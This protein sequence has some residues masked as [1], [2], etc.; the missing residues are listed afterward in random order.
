MCNSVIAWFPLEARGSGLRANNRFCHLHPSA[1]LYSPWSFFRDWGH[2]GVRLGHDTFSLPIGKVNW[3]IAP[4][5]SLAIAH[6]FPPWA[7]IIERQIASPIPIP[8]GLV[9]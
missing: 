7:S 8:C 4:R 3:K 9:V 6:N 1:Q 5:S 2:Y